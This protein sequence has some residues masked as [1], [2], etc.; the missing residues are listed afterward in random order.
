MKAHYDVVIIGSGAGGGTAADVI[1]REAPGADVLLLEGGP[2]WRHARFNE[3]ERD[4]ARL[5]VSR[6]AMFSKQMTIGVA[7]A[8]AVGG[9][10]L[11]YTGVSFRPPADVI[12]TWRTRFGLSFLTDDFVTSTLDAIES[13]LNVHALPRDWDNDNNRLF[14]EACDAL[15]IPAKRLRINVRGCEE[16]GFCNLGCRVGAKQGTLEVQLPRAQERGLTLVHNAWVDRITRDTVHFTIRPPKPRTEP[17][18]VPEGT[19]TVTAD[20]IVVAA[21]ALHTPALLLRSQEG[22]GIENDTI[23]R[24]LTLHPAYN[25][26][27]IYPEDITNYRGFPKTWYVD[28]FSGSEGYYLE[29]SFY[30]PGVTAK[31][32][33]HFG[34]VH[35]RFMQRYRQMMSILILAH[36][37]PQPGNRITIDRDG[38]SVIDYTV[39]ADVKTSLAKALRRSARLFMAAGCE[40]MMLPGSRKTVLTPDDEPD[41]ESHITPNSLSFYQSPLSSA[42]PQGGA[43]M[44]H[45]PIESVVTPEGHLHGVDRVFV[46]DASLF[47]TSSKVNPYETV[48]LLATHVGQQVAGRVA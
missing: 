24:Y 29:T 34:A 46:A 47:P 42:H 43:R 27:A 1:T 21:G 31:N 5:Y 16:L 36:D 10:T 33:P 9:S 48:M 14:K 20:Q 2:L 3:R 7:A 39:S 32:Q 12:A 13:D 25:V 8:N 37:A 45:D 26:N 41:L 28:A 6:G 15:D 23:G 4:M 38:Q 35:E 40:E 11:V 30:F 22:L 19:H 44:G 18:V 17:N